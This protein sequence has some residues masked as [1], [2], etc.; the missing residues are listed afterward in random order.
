MLRFLALAPFLLLVAP[1][2]AA[3]RTYSVSSF[4]RIRVDGPFK[5]ELTLGKAPSGKAEGDTRSTDRLDLR[6]EGDTLIV[7]AGTGAWEE[8]AAAKKPTQ[9]PTATVIRVSTPNLTGA[10]VIGGGQLTIAGPMRGQRITLALTGSGSLTAGGVAADQLIA[11]V[12]GSGTLTLAGKAARARLS[13]N[14]TTR[15]VADKLVADD[16]TLRTD[17]NG[18]TTARARYTANVNAAGVGAVTVLGTATCVVNKNVQG[19]VSCGAATAP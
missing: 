3:E 1:A 18:E 9:S 7:R 6:V 10:T 19:P 2:S 17:G 5:V 8:Q 11:T 15:I 16:L 13:A 12:T 4:E 14:G